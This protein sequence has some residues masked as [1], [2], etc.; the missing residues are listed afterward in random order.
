M[1]VEDD[2]DFFDT[3]PF[4][5]HFH[6]PTDCPEVCEACGHKC[7]EH[8]YIDMSPCLVDGCTCRAWKE[9]KME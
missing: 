3:G 6:D 5:R 4:C 1:A 2:G 7:S 9:N 8:D